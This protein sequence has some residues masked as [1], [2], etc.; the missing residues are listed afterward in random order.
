MTSTLIPDAEK[1]TSYYL[2]QHPAVVALDARIVGKTPSSTAAPWVRVT[3]LDASQDDTSQ[4]DHLVEFYLQLDCYAG[5][6]GGQPE[7]SL[8]ARTVRAAV[9]DMPGEHD[10][11]IVTRARISGAARVPDQA[12]EPA[13]ERVIV[14]AIVTAHPA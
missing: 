2:R 6:T 11:C 9:I 14:T 1:V 8:L 4:F 3:Q 13:R 7:A 10:D 5:A 12:L